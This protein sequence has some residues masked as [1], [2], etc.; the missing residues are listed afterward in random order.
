VR[1]RAML[2][3]S[4]AGQITAIALG[5]VWVSLVASASAAPTWLSPVGL[6]AAGQNAGYSQVAVDANGDAVAVWRRSNGTNELIEA[7][8][9]QAEG[10]WQ[11]P[12]Q[13]SATGQNA[14]GPQVAIDAQGDAVAV[15]G[16]S[17]GALTIIQASSKP[18]GGA[19]ETPVDLSVPGEE[20]IDPQVA[21]DPQGE[22]VAVWERSN[23]ENEIV[24]AASRPAGGAWQTPV[25]L[26]VT[27]ENG[28]FPQVAVDPQGEAVAVWERSNGTTSRFIEAASR[29]PGGTWQVPVHI[30]A[31]G[32]KAY[33]PQV[34]LDAQGDAV[35]V[36]QRYNGTDYVVQAAG[37]A[38]GGAWEAPVDLSAAGEE[39]V[40]QQVAIDTKGD[41]VAVWQHYNG[42]NWLIA[43][44]S[45]LAGGA[46]QPPV[47]LSATGENAYSPQ[48]AIDPEGAAVAV[49]NQSAVQ[50]ASGTVGGGWQAPV[51]ISNN[52]QNAQVAVDPQGNAT[53]V[54]EA[55][56]G[57][58]SIVHAAGYD[59]AG[60]LLRSLSM[61]TTGIAGQPLSFSVSP[62]DVWSALGETSWSF[63]DGGGARGT[64]ATHTYASAGTYAVTLTSADAIG[65]TTSANGTVTVSAPPGSPSEP[66]SPPG[67][68]GSQGSAH[69]ARVGLVKRGKALLK[70]TCTNAGSCQ[71]VAQLIVPRR[72]KGLLVGRAPFGIPAGKLR[73]VPIKLSKN[74]DALVRGAGRRGLTVRLSGPGVTSRTVVLKKV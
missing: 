71:G 29:P 33:G 47:D 51:D 62:F 8:S 26:S 37:G 30:S 17:N 32:E 2:V 63:G 27:G 36:W 42:T 59:A 44:A 24:Q 53:A 50:A 65:N 28:V 34:A 48:V 19:W 43:A 69:G 39:T 10:T 31:A 35:A 67:Q 49:W 4:R 16:R 3:V 20:A 73:V 55:S 21:V 38:A 58:N 12:V 41:A 60:P 40:A 74:G 23:G 68:E 15:W 1:T 11:A 56:N 70:L 54:W 18:A 9:R 72:S 13:L 52:G 66:A 5:F 57:A 64:S 7:A 61:P 6:S 45:R 25:D 14:Y 46:W 22:A